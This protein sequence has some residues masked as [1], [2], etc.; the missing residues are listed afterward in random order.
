MRTS[1]FRQF[2]RPG[3]RA[4][5]PGAEGPAR[6]PGGA[7]AAP[8]RLD[9]RLRLR[10]RRAAL[11]RVLG[12]LHDGVSRVSRALCFQSIQYSVGCFAGVSGVLSECVCFNNILITDQEC[13]G[14][15]DGVAVVVVAGQ[16]CGMR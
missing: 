2:F 16:G 11:L 15:F 5:V 7:R 9:H 14:C 13:L 12:R 1:A 4:G 8:E 3:P 10:G 6:R